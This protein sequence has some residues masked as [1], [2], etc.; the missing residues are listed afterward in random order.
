MDFFLNESLCTSNEVTIK[1]Q[2]W[3]WCVCVF[4][5]CRCFDN[6]NEPT[7]KQTSHVPLQPLATEEMNYQ[8]PLTSTK[9]VYINHYVT[10]S[11]VQPIKNQ[12]PK[13]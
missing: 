8:P 5:Y 9:S 13:S 6:V 12:T 3:P 11:H 2:G 7:L 1:P 4:A 10:V